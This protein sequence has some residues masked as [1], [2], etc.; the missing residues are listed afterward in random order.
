MS[1]PKNLRRISRCPAEERR[2]KGLWEVAV[3]M[4]RCGKRGKVP[5]TAT[6]GGEG[7]PGLFHPSHRAW[8]SRPKPRRAISTF[9]PATAAVRAPPPTFP[10]RS[11]LD[12]SLHGIA[13]WKTSEP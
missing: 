8:K 4:T 7:R 3:E 10:R 9:P 1:A 12:A 6:R 5:P 2:E 11:E 13:S